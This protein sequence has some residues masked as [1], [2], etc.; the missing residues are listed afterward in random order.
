[1]IGAIQRGV[2]E[3]L[4]F[5]AIVELVGD[6]LREVFA[7][8]DASI[9]WW[10]HDTDLVRVLYRYEH[11]AALPLPPPRKLT[12]DWG[13]Y[14]V[15][16]D[17]HVGVLNTRAE[18]LAVSITPRPGTDW[19]RSM[20]TVPIIGSR[21]LGLVNLQNR[22]RE[23][24]Y[25]EAEVRLLQTIA[26]SMGVA[27]ENAR[28]VEETKVALERQ[29][30]TA[31]VLQVISN[32]VADAQPVL[33]KILESCSHLFDAQ[34]LSVMLIEEDGLL[35]LSASR[36][37][38]RS[39]DRAAWTQA[40]YAVKGEK[41]RALFPMPL[42]GTGT[43]EAIASGR[44]L[45]FP[46]VLNGADVPHGVRA[47][48]QAM[49]INYSQMMAPLMQGTR[50]LGAISLARPALG[51]FTDAEQ[52]LLKTFADQ[53]VIAIQNANMFNETKEAL[54]RQIATADVLQVISR[55]MAD[56]KP[57]FAAII[58][59]CE[60]LLN[61]GYT[62][63]AMIGQDGL[64][65]LTQEGTGAWD[66]D[67]DSRQALTWTQG[68]FPRPVRDS[69]HGYAIHKG[70]VLNFP[71]VA[72]G[73]GVPEGLRSSAAL[74]NYS[75]L[76]APMYWEGK[77]IGAIAVHRK[78]PAPF[79]EK[80]AG[81]L[82]TFADQA[83][84]AIQNAKMFNAL[85]A[86]NREVSQ[87]LSQQTATAEVLQVVSASMAD[88]QPV[89]EKILESCGRLF[90]AWGMVVNLLGDDGLIY[91][92]AMRSQVDQS[93]PVA[94]DQMRLIEALARSAYPMKLSDAARAAVQHIRHVIA[95]ADVLN[96]PGVP[97]GM[98]APALKIGFGY[99]QMMA[100]L[101]VADRYIGSI[102]VSRDAGDGFSVMEQ[103]LLKTFA[104]Q[105]VIAI[106]NARLFNET[107]EALERQTATAEILKVI[108]GSPDSVQPVFDAIAAS[109]NR[110]LDGF[111]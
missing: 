16:K 20:V 52:A 46:D 63:L 65:H 62:N 75:A 41:I 90:K 77:G 17:R 45:N 101:F 22:E 18:M 68:Q 43:A 25:S 6:K 88:A 104:D 69:I 87:A 40:D 82:K 105:A 67:E 23:H 73:V 66:E 35:H 97:F 21:V 48:A 5:Q 84:I 58:A 57:V 56:A 53:A 12:A 79:S 26:A 76:Y 89:L 111:S 1:M 94:A 49:G 38:F 51:G 96:E 15:L 93:D 85:E 107:K 39:G 8:G 10:D 2:A 61:A 83:V 60:E 3:Q 81:L 98:R 86:R 91:L 19:C 102:A 4:D 29:T 106:Q 24:A 108:A 103:A 30:A 95:A 55:S 7:T 72:N 11:G 27:L 34:V 28:L 44:V 80:D 33:E 31:E 47:P 99:A 92:A 9:A 110:L 59:S 13:G 64:M 71:D 37:D 14:Q 100:P 42:A 54:E 32:S 36:A 70:E 78:P 109:S 74:G 50:G